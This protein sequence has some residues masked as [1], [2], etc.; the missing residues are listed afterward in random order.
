VGDIGSTDVAAYVA[1]I[2]SPRRRRDAETMLG[3]MQRA[4]RQSPELW[5]SIVGYGRYHYRYASGREGDAPAAG[6]A[7]RK[8]AIVVYVSDG[9]GRHED[10]L[11]RLGPH[12]TGVACIYLRDVSAVDALVLEAIVSRSYATL[13]D[14]TYTNRAR[15]GT[16]D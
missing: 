8:T 9:V 10:L 1:A 11:A 6:F 16:T 2:A 3:V 12:T 5:G 4:T 7:A 13:T 14:G 15:V